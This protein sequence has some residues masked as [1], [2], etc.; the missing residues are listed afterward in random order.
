MWFFRK[1]ELS[2]V[3][4]LRYCSYSKLTLPAWLC[5]GIFGIGLLEDAVREQHFERVV[6]LLEQGFSPNGERG[7]LKVGCV[8]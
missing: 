3:S 5:S 7:S 8:F 6:A 1:G 2:F 4:M